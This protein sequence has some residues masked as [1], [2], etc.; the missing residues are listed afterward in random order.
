MAC[1]TK[2]SNDCPDSPS[3]ALLPRSSS[4]F[5]RPSGNTIA[6][7]PS[8]A[9]PRFNKFPTARQVLTHRKIK[10]ERRSWQPVKTRWQAT[11][12]SG[13]SRAIP[14]IRAPQDTL[15]AQSGLWASTHKYLSGTS[16]CNISDSDTSSWRSCSTASFW[17]VAAALSAITASGGKPSGNPSNASTACAKCSAG[18]SL[19]K[20]IAS[21]C[22][23]L[24]SSTRNFF[25]ASSPEFS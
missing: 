6:L 22:E 8:L 23:V 13:R 9:V 15:A 11:D 2:S 24:S 21:N 18:G 25:R 16:S 20:A 5:K 3:L 19:L 7:A 12:S 10:W 1:A 17:S 14:T 4:N